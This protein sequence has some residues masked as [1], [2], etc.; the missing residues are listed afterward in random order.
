[1][2]EE[3]AEWHCIEDEHAFLLLCPLLCDIATSPAPWSASL[4]S[5]VGF[6]D[7]TCFGQWDIKRY[8]PSRGLKYVC[9]VHFSFYVSVNALER[10]SG[11]NKDIY[12]QHQPQNEDKWMRSW[13]NPCRAAKHSW[14]HRLKPTPSKEPSLSQQDTEHGNNCLLQ[15][16]KWVWMYLLHNIVLTIAVT[17]AVTEFSKNSL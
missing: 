10:A 15:F 8:D 2:T 11:E 16:L 13:L 9:S 6:D 7:V 1:M 14:T 3:R 12:Y 4:L 5:D 17:I